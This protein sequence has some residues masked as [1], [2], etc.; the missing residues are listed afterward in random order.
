MGRRGKAIMGYVWSPGKYKIWKTIS[1]LTNSLN[2][3]VKLEPTRCH[4]CLIVSKYLNNSHNTLSCNQLV[5]I[6]FYSCKLY[7]WLNNYETRVLK[8]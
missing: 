7:N 6:Y 4:I 2:S 1:N 8:E 5:F 3:S